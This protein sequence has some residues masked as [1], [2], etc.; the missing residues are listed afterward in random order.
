MT[1]DEVKPSAGCWKIQ[2][3]GLAVAPWAGE[4]VIKNFEYLDALFALAGNVVVSEYI[5]DHCPRPWGP[6][7]WEYRH[8]IP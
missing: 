4:W 1:H 6:A 3:W 2:K 7:E 8:G 5:E